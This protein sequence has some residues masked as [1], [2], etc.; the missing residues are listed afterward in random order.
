MTFLSK[1]HITE[2][3]MLQNQSDRSYHHLSF[4]IKL[5]ILTLFH[6]VFSY[7]Y[8]I[9]T[10]CGFR[11]FSGLHKTEIHKET[12]PFFILP[13]ELQI[14]DTLFHSQTI[15]HV[16]CYVSDCSTERTSF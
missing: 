6:L 16:C 1:W 11:H 9:K 8:Q 12:E 5:S 15:P 3:Q 13:W 14:N 2:I 4:Y 7:F 10:I